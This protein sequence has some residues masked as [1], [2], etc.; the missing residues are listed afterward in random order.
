MRPVA[1]LPHLTGFRITLL[2]CSARQVNVRIGAR[3]ATAHCPLCGRRSARRHSCYMRTLAD[4]PWSGVP[5]TLQLQT[6][7]FFCANPA[8]RRRIFAERFPALVADFSRR[9]LHRHAALE[10]IGFALGGAAGA[11]LA[12]VLGLATS[13]ATLLRTVQR[14][15]LPTLLPATVVGV[16]DWSFRRG[17]RFGTILCDLERHRVVDLL[18]DRSAASVGAWLQAH[19]GVTLA[20]RDRSELYADGIARGAPTALQVAD[21]FHVLKNLV[22]AL[23]R[24]LHRKRSAL[25]A[26]EQHNTATVTTPVPTGQA[27]QQRAAAQR[28]LRHSPWLARYEQVLA[29]HAR[30]ADLA[31][32]ARSVGIS[33]TTVY[34]YVRLDGPPAPKQPR[35]RRT[36]LDPYVAHLDQRWT[37]G[38]HNAKRLF[39]EI[40]AL[41]Y[42]ASYTNVSRFV[43][44]RRLAVGQRPSAHRPRPRTEALTPR[45]V[46]FLLI[47][48]PVSLTDAQRATLA[49]LCQVE[50]SIAAVYPLA[51]T[52]V[53]L[54][55]THA[56][57]RLPAWITE[58]QASGVEELARF[59]TG[60]LSD[61]PAI[62][63]G[64][65]LPWSQGQVEGQVNRL[66]R[67]KRLL[68][69]RAGFA[70]LRHM[71][72]H[73]SRQIDH[74][75]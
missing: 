66:K 51:Q 5:V 7:R 70:L 46:A 40:R 47:R 15:A 6:R 61:F 27:W 18:P 38:C 19:P 74:R 30:G 73:Q 14:S 3:R 54:L 25:T 16:D 65:T 32:I 9:T 31:D 60:L 35:R 33:R 22:E 13:G 28:S 71:V 59:A 11:R 45:H 24:H 68:Y 20:T 75:K 55:H 63:A 37:E 67:I 23:E 49:A 56:G 50:A 36:V 2:D 48:P 42:H 62:Q 72:L 39:H 44:D 10:H 57:E 29:L 58:A 53:Q 17:Q 12:T 8:C 43:A 26:L 52:F 64:F 1:F 21:R 69:G 4:L 34:R 41:G